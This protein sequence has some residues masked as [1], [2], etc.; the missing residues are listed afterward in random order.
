MYKDL[1]F[2]FPHKVHLS[3]LKANIINDINN[4]E[5]KFRDF[6]QKQVQDKR[7]ALEEELRRRIMTYER[8]FELPLN[9]EADKV[10]ASIEEVRK[11]NLSIKKA[12]SFDEWV[13]IKSAEN[14]FD[15]DLVKEQYHY[16][17]TSSEKEER[18]RRLWI[19]SKSTRIEASIGIPYFND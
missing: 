11:K 7:V 19:D 5:D 15:Q 9:C 6:E 8:Y 10:D 16:F 3:E 2:E 4:E 13:K 14:L 17:E 18:I 12:Y 1:E